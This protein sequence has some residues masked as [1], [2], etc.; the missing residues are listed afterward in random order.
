MMKKLMWILVVIIVIAGIGFGG[1]KVYSIG[2]DG[3]EKTGYDT[4]YSIGEDKGYQSGQ[5]DGY[6]E[7]YLTGTDDGM[8]EG[9]KIGFTDG[10][11]EGEQD[12]YQSGYSSGL[13]TG[14]Q[15]GYQN[16]Y[17]EGQTA[18]YGTGL[19]AG[20]GHGYTIKDPTFAEVQDFLTKDRTDERTYIDPTYVCSHFSRDVCN[21]AEA[22]G[23]RCAVVELRYTSGNGHLIIAFNTLD[24]GMVY[25][26]SQ[27]DE[28]AKPALGLKYYTTIIVKPGYYYPPPAQDDTIQDMVVI[29]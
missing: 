18:G 24:K 28:Q 1:Y 10:Y 22:A 29:W 12:G 26:E 3:G 6:T 19:T 8:V 27:T 20:F 13:A 5:K 2:Y 9:K 11:G 25:F 16:G 21:N 23:I 4:G 17:S 7:G 14:T 15:Q